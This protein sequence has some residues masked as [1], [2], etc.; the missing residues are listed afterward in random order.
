MIHKL[1]SS[2]LPSLT[3]TPITPIVRAVKRKKSSIMAGSAHETKEQIILY[4]ALEYQISKRYES[5]FSYLVVPN[6]SSHTDI[7]SGAPSLYDNNSHT[8]IDIHVTDIPS[9]DDITSIIFSDYTRLLEAHCTLMRTNRG[10]LIVI[11]INGAGYGGPDFRVWNREFTGDELEENHLVLTDRYSSTNI[12]R[13]HYTLLSTTMDDLLPMTGRSKGHHVSDSV[14]RD[15]LKQGVLKKGG[16]KGLSNVWAQLGCAFEDSILQHIND[17]RPGSISCSEEIYKDGIY[18]TMDFYEKGSH[19]VGEIKLPW[20]SSNQP[21]DGKKMSRFINQVMAYC[22]ILG[23]RKAILIACFINGN[24][25]DEKIPTYREW[26]LEF[27][28]VELIK[29]WSMIQA[30]T[31][32]KK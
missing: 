18:G 28:N 27:T 10:S 22:H 2:T 9:S 19:A 17:S 4:R 21:I 30:M 26:E 20:M 12:K 7:M 25:K 15:A 31:E 1:K 29:N 8:A 3:G 23:V 6:I 32:D 5:H 11:Y 24:Y 14:K 16:E 13:S